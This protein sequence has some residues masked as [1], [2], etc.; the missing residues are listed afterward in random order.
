[1]IF[2]LFHAYLL[3]SLPIDAAELCSDE[4]P[5]LKLI[6]SDYV[7]LKQH[8]VNIYGPKLEPKTCLMYL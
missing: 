2:I 4:K 6:A 1:M 7:S 5:P 3:K 8:L